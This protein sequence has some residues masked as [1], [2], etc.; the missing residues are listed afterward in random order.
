[1][2]DYFV[3]TSDEDG[4][5]I[6][7]FSKKEL[8]KELEDG[9]IESLFKTSIENASML[10]YWGD[11]MLIIKGNIIVPEPKKEVTVWEV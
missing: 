7:R 9:G 5:H 1:M 6:Q 8:E 3:I 10:S 2:S 4:G 11:E